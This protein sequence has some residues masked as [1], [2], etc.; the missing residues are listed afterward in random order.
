MLYLLRSSEAI[1][2]RCPD[3]E[4]LTAFSERILNGEKYELIQAHLDICPRCSEIH[5]RLLRFEDASAFLPES[6]WQNADKRLGNWME[7][8]L[9]ED[10][11]A[12]QVDQTHQ[13]RLWARFSEW[14]TIRQ[15]C[16]ALAAT[17]ALVL[18]AGISLQRLYRYRMAAP[19]PV[20][21]VQKISP[22]KSDQQLPPTA[23]MGSSR[24]TKI[25][26]PVAALQEENPSHSRPAQQDLPTIEMG[27]SRPR[28]ILDFTP[29]SAS[30][31][32]DP[33]LTAALGASPIRLFTT[34]IEV[35]TAI[36][37]RVDSVLKKNP[38]GGAMFRGLLVQPLVQG[39]KEIF[40][41]NSIVV[42]DGQVS[43]REVSLR[44]AEIRVQSEHRVRTTRYVL[45]PSEVQP[46]VLSQLPESLNELSP[47]A[48]VELR[49][50]T[51]SPY[52]SREDRPK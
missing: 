2:D 22:P 50:V 1:G 31:S 41:A 29:A 38:A 6:E 24:P 45:A 37:V 42:A 34:R 33:E 20:A 27:S 10:S 36:L 12:A 14:I 7:S 44:V 35:G 26:P 13:A 49:F 21:S 8:F 17:T 47:G 19:L 4:S 46:N 52:L 25:E 15:I 48:T 23:E 3:A 11:A 30:D 28:E 43:G 40:P 16:Y 51:S 39:G 9:P 18:V 32:K 5:Q